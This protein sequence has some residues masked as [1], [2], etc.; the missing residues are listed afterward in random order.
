MTRRDRDFRAP[1]SAADDAW[2]LRACLG[3][4]GHGS[5]FL[6]PGVYRTEAAARRAAATRLGKPTGDRAAAQS[7][8]PDPDGTLLCLFIVRPDGTSYRYLPNPSTDPSAQS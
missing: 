8:G 2:L 6:L 5:S 3:A 1:S 7:G 4:D